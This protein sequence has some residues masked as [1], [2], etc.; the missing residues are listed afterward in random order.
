M[1]HNEIIYLSRIYISEYHASKKQCLISNDILKEA[2]GQVD[3]GEKAAAYRFMLCQ[4]LD[5]DQ[6]PTGC[7]WKKC[8]EDLDEY[9]ANHLDIQFRISQ[10]HKYLHVLKK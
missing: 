8:V 4:F 9:I 6:S 1:Q 3:R 7:A 2:E 10:F 5:A